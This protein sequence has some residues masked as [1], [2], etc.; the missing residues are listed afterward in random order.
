MT[1]ISLVVPVFNEREN[2][3]PLV[4]E[5]ET[6]ARRH[7]WVYELLLVNDG[8]D[9]GSAETIDE[10][11]ATRPEVRGLHLDRNHGQSAA[12]AAGFERAR[13]HYVVTLDADG[14]N[15]P[16]DIPA[17]IDLLTDYDLAIGYRQ[18]RV[19][20]WL[21]RATSWM[22]NRVRNGLTGEHIVDT[23]CTLKAFRVGAVR[24]LIEYKGMH[25][26]LPTLARI[27]GLS[28]VEHPVR[29]R[30]RRWGRS[31]YGIVARGLEGLGDLVAVRWM[32]RRRLDHSSVRE[33]GA[34][35]LAERVAAIDDRRGA[36][37]AVGGRTR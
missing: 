22:A 18:R 19:D 12:I 26:F 36:G 37:S 3:A 21:R 14:Q 5:I 1:E 6:V 31:K 32:K 24:G 11:A 27:R 10:L 30:P 4:D 17:L 2:L 23:G 8:S 33:S 15:D 7:G 16:A 29:H 35:E 13:G 25:R 20:G 9:D 28:L 34:A